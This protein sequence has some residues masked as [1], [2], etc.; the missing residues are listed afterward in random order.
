MFYYWIEWQAHSL[1]F[2]RYLFGGM[3]QVTTELL[4]INP[5]EKEIEK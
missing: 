3:N 5:R 1:P 4:L 2:S